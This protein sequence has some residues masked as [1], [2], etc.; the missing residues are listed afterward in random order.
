MNIINSVNFLS[1]YLNAYVLIKPTATNII[2]NFLAGG[3]AK[4]I[5]SA[6]GQVI[7]AYRVGSTGT[8]ARR[9]TDGGTTWSSFPSMTSANYGM[10]CSSSGQYVVVCA[11]NNVWY[12]TNYGANWT[13]TSVPLLCQDINGSL[14]FSTSSGYVYTFG[15]SDQRLISFTNNAGSSFSNLNQR[16]NAPV[17]FYICSKD[18]T[19]AIYIT[20]NNN[21]N[22]GGTA[23]RKITNMQTST[24]TDTQLSTF[25]SIGYYSVYRLTADKNS[26]TYIMFIQQSNIYLSTD[27]GTTFNNIKT[28]SP[29][30]NYSNFGNNPSCAISF[31]GKYMA[32]STNVADLIYSKDYGNSWSVL[33]LS[34]S[35]VRITDLSFACSTDTNNTNENLLLITTNSYGIYKCPII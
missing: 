11:G 22:N 10:Y 16:T 24:P 26:L 19:S 12:S 3:T 35:G 14:D 28:I 33:T 31:S 18:G 17:E 1:Q 7:Y 20:Y 34:P 15:S 9:T 32:L 27:G 23:I 8:N 13:I 21:Y 25:S 29:I 2:A 6:D 30:S 5:C 4:T